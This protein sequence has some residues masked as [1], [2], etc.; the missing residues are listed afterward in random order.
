MPALIRI[1]YFSAGATAAVFIEGTWQHDIDT[2]IAASMVGAAAA[3][4][5]LIFEG[6]DE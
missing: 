5:I 2:M 3:V 1:C 6:S 4:G